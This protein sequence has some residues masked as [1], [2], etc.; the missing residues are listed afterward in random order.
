MEQVAPAHGILPE[1]G[2]G[3]AIVAALADEWGITETADGKRVW[4]R[5]SAQPRS[6][7]SGLNPR[8]SVGEAICPHCAPAA[9]TGASTGADPVDTSAANWRCDSD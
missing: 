8:V 2:R 3:L 5:W 6:E 7:R 1:G 4:A 9:G